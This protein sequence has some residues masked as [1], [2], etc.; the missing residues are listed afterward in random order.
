[1][2][3]KIVDDE[4]YQ[5]INIKPIETKDANNSLESAYTYFIQSSHQLLRYCLY[6]KHKKIEGYKRFTNDPLE[7]EI[8]SDLYD[9]LSDIYSV[10]KSLYNSSPSVEKYDC[11]ELVDSLKSDKLPKL[12]KV[13]K[14][15]ERMAQAT[16]ELYL[17]YIALED[18]NYTWS[19]AYKAIFDE[20]NSLLRVYL[21]NARLGKIGGSKGKT[22]P[23]IL[24]AIYDYHD[25]YLSKR[26]DNDSFEI[27]APPAVEK[28]LEHFGSVPYEVPTLV[29]YI[30]Q[31]RRNNF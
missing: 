13:D 17:T 30:K 27:K 24:Q 15:F 28:I 5:I 1:M 4:P 31:H 22:D 19:L 10:A 23:K 14:E 29:N 6:A 3:I 7:N 12:F 26:K 11:F 16:L 9:V 2:D 25:K 8:I 18:E 21:N 20:S